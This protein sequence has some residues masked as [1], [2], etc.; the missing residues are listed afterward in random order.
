MFDVAFVVSYLVLWLV[1]AIV[2]IAS[3]AIV[4][5]LA[6]IR[7]RLGPEPGALATTDGPKIGS[8]APPLEGAFLDRGVMTIR[9][10]PALIIWVSPG[11][12]ACLELLSQLARFVRSARI[13]V[14]V[15]CQGTEE[16]TRTLLKTY[17]VTVPVLVDAD[18]KVEETFAIRLT[19]FAVAMDSDWTVRTK[20]VV[21]NDDQ[22][23][24][25]ANFEITLQ[26]SRV[27][28]PR[29]S[30]LG[31]AGTVTEKPDLARE[32]SWRSSTW[33]L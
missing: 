21:N 3:L 15:V 1:L 30:P 26:G 11:C 32:R 5:E 12:R 19:P 28:V 16:Q 4:R 9:A 27:W 20:G 7:V 18:R 23:E 6:L 14:Y 17:E 24:S 33:K 8:I 10:G 13:P 29:D 31:L 2:V 25:L 22:L